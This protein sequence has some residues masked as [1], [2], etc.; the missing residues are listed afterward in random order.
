MFAFS[1]I[2]LYL[3]LDYAIRLCLTS[4]PVVNVPS[5][6]YINFE[7]ELRVTIKSYSEDTN[8]W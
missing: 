8:A 1:V 6:I 7:S 4:P 2:P 5:R 3:K